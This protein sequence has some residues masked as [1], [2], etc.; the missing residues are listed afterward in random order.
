M[1]T[2]TLSTC[3]I[4]VGTDL[5]LIEFWRMRI[6]VPV[7][8]PKIELEFGLG[9]WSVI[10]Y[11]HTT[12]ESGTKADHT[13]TFKLTRRNEDLISIESTHTVDE[14]YQGFSIASKSEGTQ[15]FDAV[16]LKLDMS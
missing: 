5:R 9:G 13:S 16:G 1:K 3:L 14:S 10:S 11:L 12:Q 2:N 15:S 4:T 6:P 8:M 7:K